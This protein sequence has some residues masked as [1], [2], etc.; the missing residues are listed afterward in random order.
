MTLEYF[1]SE[2]LIKVPNTKTESRVVYKT[3]LTHK[4]KQDQPCGQ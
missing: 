3:S 4:E 2:V 1:S